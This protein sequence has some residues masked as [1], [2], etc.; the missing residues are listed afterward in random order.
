VGAHAYDEPLAQT[1]AEE[2]QRENA[3]IF[4]RF[5]ML[6]PRVRY[7]LIVLVALLVFLPASGLFVGLLRG[8]EFTFSYSLRLAYC[9]TRMEVSLVTGSRLPTACHEGDDEKVAYQTLRDMFAAENRDDEAD[10]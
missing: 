7:P 9:S 2:W 1:T 10:K 3:S 5:Q 8:F 6:R 4:G